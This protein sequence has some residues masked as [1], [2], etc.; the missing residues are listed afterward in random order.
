MSRPAVLIGSW[1]AFMLVPFAIARLQTPPRWRARLGF[2]AIVGMVAS[3]AVLLAVVLMP[4]ALGFSSIRQIWTICSSAFHSIVRHPLGMA[5]SILAGIVLGVVLGRFG[6]T[7]VHGFLATRAARIRDLRPTRRLDGGQSVYVVPLDRLEAYCLGSV[8]G[9]VVISQG[10]LDALDEDELEAVLLHEEG[11]LR[12]WHQPLLL[13]ARSAAA[14]LRPIRSARTAMALVEQAL[15]EVADDY[16]AARLGRPSLVAKSISKAAL[17][18]LRNPVGTVAVGADPDAPA[19]VRRL[20]DPPSVAPW[21]PGVCGGATLAL[22]ALIGVTQ[23][24]AGVTVLAAAHHFL[25]LGAASFCPL[26]SV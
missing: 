14:A 9:Q 8:R 20:L 22:I 7:L 12:S 15:E 1:L 16:A 6:W 17:Y 25:G 4:E 24:V 11:H 10:L 13:V 3:S 2:I 19:R 18:G 21:V 23:T 5:P 26:R